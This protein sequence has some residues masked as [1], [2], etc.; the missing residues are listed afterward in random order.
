[1]HRS[2]AAAA[3]ALLALV[4]EPAD[5]VRDVAWGDLRDG[6]L[7]AAVEVGERVPLEVTAWTAPGEPV[8]FADAV[9]Q[10]AHRR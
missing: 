7:Q 8:P 9:R 3:A 1:M 6:A 4:A 10:A 5:E 2:K